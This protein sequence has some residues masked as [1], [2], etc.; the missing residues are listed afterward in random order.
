MPHPATALDESILGDIFSHL[1]LADLAHLRT[2]STG[3]RDAAAQEEAYRL[4]YL[5]LDAIDPG[6]RRA[7]HLKDK[8]LRAAGE[9]G[10]N[11]QQLCE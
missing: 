5:T 7:A 8:A 1:S 11:W 2:V 6:T 10:V 3:W 9:T 4:A